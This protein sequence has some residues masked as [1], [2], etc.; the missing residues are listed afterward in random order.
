MP[1]LPITVSERMGGRARLPALQVLLVMAKR[2]I[3]VR[4][5]LL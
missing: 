4:R 2:R 5:G 3:K 1:D